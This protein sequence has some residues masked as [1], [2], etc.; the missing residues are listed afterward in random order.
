MPQRPRACAD[1]LRMSCLGARG[2]A[3]AAGAPSRCVAAWV[4]VR[5]RRLQC[6]CRGWCSVVPRRTCM[7]CAR[8]GR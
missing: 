1:W 7:F 2:S 4:H 6:A 3:V 5:H 8:G